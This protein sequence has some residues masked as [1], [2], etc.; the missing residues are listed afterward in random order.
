MT[1]ITLD[2]VFPVVDPI[3]LPTIRTNDDNITIEQTATFTVDMASGSHISIN[4]DFED[5]SPNKTYVSDPPQAIWTN[6]WQFDH[7]FIKG[8]DCVITVNISNPTGKML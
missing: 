4:V 5:G 7:V 3:V 1:S 6:P 2:E 8:C